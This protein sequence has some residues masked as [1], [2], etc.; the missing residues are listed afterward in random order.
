MTVTPSRHNAWRLVQ[1]AELLRRSHRLHEQALIELDRIEVAAE[2]ST[3]PVTLDATVTGELASLGEAIAD[4]AGQVRVLTNDLP[5]DTIEIAAGD[6]AHEAADDLAAGIFDEQRAVLAAR[7]L[8]AADGWP[9]LADALR[10]TDGHWSWDTTSV[11]A[12]LG[13]FRYACE[14]DVARVVAAAAVDPDTPFALCTR[15][16]IVQLASALERHVTA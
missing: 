16:Q 1:V 14:G 3:A 12:L 2:L 10:S 4:L 11:A 15:E 8:H 9:A 6:V 5:E 13:S 7:V